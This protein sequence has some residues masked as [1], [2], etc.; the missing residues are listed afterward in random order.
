MLPAGD[1]LLVEVPDG[2]PKHGDAGVRLE[3]GNLQPQSVRERDVVGVQARDVATL[4]RLEAAI[5]RRRQTGPLVVAH[6]LEPR[7]GDTRQDL[8][9]CIG[10]GVVDDDELEVRQ[11]LTEHAVDRFP[12]KAG[13]VVDGHQDGDE[14]HGR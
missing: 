9:R 2:T 12:D 3:P 13:V 4:R 5:E 1:A 7:V 14:R 11:G 8:G 6:Q 10:R